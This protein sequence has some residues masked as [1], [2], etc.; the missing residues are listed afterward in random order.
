M[1]MAAATS[2]VSR[3]IAGRA[4][5][6]LGDGVVRIRSVDA[7][8]RVLADVGSYVVRRTPHGRWSCQCAAATFGNHCCH[9]EA[10]RLVT[11]PGGGQV[12]EVR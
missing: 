7:D 6:L 3:H 11:A 5:E 2:E 4:V 1:T 9:V 8:A 12:E 10:V